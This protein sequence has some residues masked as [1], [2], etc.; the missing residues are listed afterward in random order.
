MAADHNLDEEFKRRGQIALGQGRMGRV[1]LEGQP[2]VVEDV[3]TDPLY[4]HKDEALR[5]GIHSVAIV[6][7]RGHDRIIGVLN[8]YDSKPRRF[9]DEEIASLSEFANL[10]TLAIQ[11]ARLLEDLVRSHAEVARH[12]EQLHELYRLG[13]T[14]Q[15]ALPLQER[16]DLI[17]KGVHGVLGFDRIAIFLP[18]PR[19]EMLE[20]CAT[21]GNLADPVEQIK[22]PLGRDGGILARTFL[23]GQEIVW[24]SEDGLPA[25]LRL[26]PP[27]SQIETLHSRTF[28]IFPLVSRERVIGLLSAD[29]KLSRRPFPEETLSLLRPFA[30]QAA[31]A[32]ENARLYEDSQ[33]RAR[34]ATALTEV[35][36][37]LSASLDMDRVFELI[38][39]EV[40]RV[41]EAPFVGIL[42]L[43]EGRQELAYVKAA[44]LSA[45]RMAGLRLKVGEGIAGRAV[46]ERV[47][48][49]SSKLLE[50]PRF[51]AKGL[52]E[53]E[54]FRSLLCAPLMAGGRPLGVLALFRQEQHEFAPAEVQLLASFA[55]QAAIAIENA[56]LFEETK[57][58]AEEQ[59]TLNAIAAATGRS[60]D[61]GEVLDLALER[62]LTLLGMD[63]GVIRLLN[64]A[65]DCFI[66]A[67]GRGL[68]R[69]YPGGLGQVP[70]G[71]GFSGQLA[72]CREPVFVNDVPSDPRFI[73]LGKSEGAASAIGVPLTAKAGVVGVMTLFSRSPRH[74]EPPPTELL[75]N[76]GHQV[77]MA[78]E[79]AR[80]FEEEHQ[81]R[82]QLEAVRAVTAEITREL[83]L[84]TL[85][86]LIHRRAAEL[87][88]AV[89]GA[90]LL[91][92]E[93]AQVLVP[94]AW[95]GFGEWMGEVRRRLGEGISGTVAQRR[96]GLIVNDYRNS[97]HA[98]SLLLERTNVT[99]T[100]AEP[101]LY[102]DQL[103]GVITIH[104]EATGRTFTEEDRQVLTLF[105]AQAAIAIENARLYTETKE[106]AARL[107]TLARLS[108]AVSSTLDRQWV[109]DDV[110]KA[111][112]QLLE[113]SYCCLWIVE[114]GEE[115]LR[116]QAEYSGDE[117]D[118]A[119][120]PQPPL[121]ITESL[122]GWALQQRQSVAVHNILEDP[123]WQNVAWAKA[124]GFCSYA[125]APLLAD[126]RPLG[127]LTVL[128]RTPRH[129]GPGD[130]DLLETFAAQAATAI[131]NA[132]LHQEIK[133]H[134]EM[135]ERRVAERTLEL[136]EANRHKSAFL[137]NM[138]HELRTPL[139][140]IIGFSEVMGAETHGPLTPKQQRYVRNI[141]QSG[142]H[143]LG[144]INDI[145]DLSKVE[146]GKMEL[147]PEAVAL[148]ALV[149]DALATIRPEAERKG[150]ALSTHLEERLPP[151][152]ADPTKAK[153]ILLNLLSNAV[154]FTPDGGKVWVQG[155]RER[156]RPPGAQVGAQGLARISVADTGIGIRPEH[157]ELIFKEF[158][159]VDSS[160][161]RQYEGTGLGLALTKRLVE[162]QGGEIWL[163]SE[164][165]KGSTFHFTLSLAGDADEAASPASE[166]MPA[167][168]RSAA[169]VLV[170][171]DDPQAA[172]LLT[173]QVEGAGCG[174]V[175]A[176]SAGEALEKARSCHPFVI[177]LDIL[178]PE[179]DGWHILQDLKSSP[180]TAEIPVVIISVVEDQRRGMALGATDYF[181][182]P[183]DPESLLGR[184]KRLAPLRHQEGLR[185]LVIDD[186]PKAI[187]I[188]AETL[189]GAGVA[190]WGAR[191]GSEGIQWAIDQKPHLII[192]DLQM[193]GVNGFEVLRQLKA[194][195]EAR[196]IPVIINTAQTLTKEDRELL[197][198][199]AERVV[200]K[201][202]E[203]ADGLL[204]E[205]ARIER[206]LGWR[207]AAVASN[208]SPP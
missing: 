149:E 18:D 106:K 164:V 89:S 55:D 168:C 82:R 66:L 207:R 114:E 22:V 9:S 116:A 40:Q 160:H 156:A 146:S 14:M 3:E 153:Q 31:I 98:H 184:I 36:R 190:V 118:V 64:E 83:D 76:V 141:H 196:Q 46:E 16:L 115:M 174:V 54:G 78:I 50:D 84:T 206:M 81:R 6:P 145:L 30:A 28:V 167:A 197:S 27:Y 61:L 120:P 26:R 152:W 125:A 135:Q 102:R 127:T 203:G 94:R 108:R 191:S 185:V 90:V 45:E 148:P 158:S 140:A 1:A 48:L 79:N 87:V 147:H 150:I 47:P 159:Q 80:L 52:A 105:A 13:I 43:D 136:E 131:E 73:R 95:H 25:D 37:V 177:T 133:A 157:F 75:A 8:V 65:K 181:V 11:K 35:G 41:M 132:S 29:N 154:K 176:Q 23:E 70:V 88:G 178:M 19:D 21:F 72:G 180:E 137:A 202:R 124:M 165:G 60:V 193:P 7:L 172:H 85:L 163:E 198:L 179:Q 187:E 144:L 93:A 97:P 20:C 51:V 205:I 38:V 130:L 99:A 77:G 183:V 188:M 186:D 32:I 101:L 96:E 169:P 15:G 53:V 208:V 119:H 139:S 109:F 103:L 126:G 113:V 74:F 173:L 110:V 58:Q 24:T 49:Q 111:A 17:L 182:K 161:A 194:H 71:E 42:T 175:V 59:R 44:G 91:W 155:G 34:E 4:H 39:Q 12:K 129:F 100:L 189:R 56:R 62:S 162:M 128:T 151:L 104:H 192:L 86:N 63:F 33:R 5:A 138:S 142:R 121:K 171:E 199:H 10:A 68:R 204:A 166:G 67:A 200:E 92:D 107:E 117:P 122:G 201:G 112:V 69:E 134:A 123:R 170:V 195:R 57:R 2:M 143:L